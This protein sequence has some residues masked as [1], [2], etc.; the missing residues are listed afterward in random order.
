[1]I[2]RFFKCNLN[3]T[4]KVN[5]NIRRLNIVVFVDVG[6]ERAVTFECEVVGKKEQNSGGVQ[7]NKPDDVART[8]EPDM[9]W[10]A[11][12]QCLRLNYQFRYIRGTC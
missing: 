10:E 12:V 6:G 7:F 11:P 2:I 9:V 3:L 8:R 5:N 4:T 1:M